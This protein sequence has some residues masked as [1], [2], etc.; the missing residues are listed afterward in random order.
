MVDSKLA[1][2]TQV[3]RAQASSLL[4]QSEALIGLTPDDDFFQAAIKDL[5]QFETN[6]NFVTDQAAF[7]AAHLRIMEISPKVKSAIAAL[8][9][10]KKATFDKRAEK[11]VNRAQVIHKEKLQ[12]QLNQI[13]EGMTQQER[14]A[15]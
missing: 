9:H 12:K 11:K 3:L 14:M 1:G 4:G 6:E 10:E 8:S 15:L 13:A 7:K 5:Q 2:L